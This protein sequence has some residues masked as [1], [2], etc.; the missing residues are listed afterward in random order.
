MAINFATKF[1]KHLD[2]RFSGSRVRQRSP[3][4]PIQYTSLTK[5]MVLNYLLLVLLLA[6]PILIV[7]GVFYDR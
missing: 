2:E 3:W 4:Q 1:P 7:Y 6:L 5:Y